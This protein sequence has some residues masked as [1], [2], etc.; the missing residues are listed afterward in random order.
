MVRLLDKIMRVINLT[1]P[2]EIPE[3]QVNNEKVR[4]TIIDAINYLLYIDAVFEKRV[5]DKN[6]KNKEEEEV[7]EQMKTEVL[8]DE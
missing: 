3:A 2:S 8:I 5:I 7:M 1:T 4:D 6:I